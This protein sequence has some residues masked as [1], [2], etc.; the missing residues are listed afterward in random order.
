V[1]IAF[2][3]SFEVFAF[4]GAPTQRTGQVGYHLQRLDVQHRDVGVKE[5]FE[6]VPQ[7]FIVISATLYRWGVTIRVFQLANQ[8]FT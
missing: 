8:L 6:T 3:N 7:A 5:L 2:K 4:T 1:S